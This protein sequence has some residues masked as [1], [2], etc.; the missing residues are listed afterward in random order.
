MLKRVMIS[1]VLFVVLLAGCSGQELSKQQYYEKGVKF[2]ESGNANGAIVVFKKAIEKDQN[3]FEARYQLGRA[4]IL[5]GKF[6][7]A[8]RELLKAL[9]LNPSF[10]D[11]HVALAKVYTM[12]LKTDEALKEINLYLNKT[13]DNPEAY[14]VAASVYAVKKDYAK[15][16]E[17][18]LQA[19]KISPQRASSKIFLADLYLMKGDVRESERLIQETLAADGNNKSALYELAKIRQKQGRQEEVLNV[20][21][22]IYDVDTKDISA[23]L[24]LGMA[25]LQNKNLKKARALAEDVGKTHKDRPESSYLMGTVY[26]YEGKTDD[27]LASLQAAA[28]KTSF[29]GLHYYIGLCHLAKGD[30]EQAISEFR[31]V[32]DMKPGMVQ[33]RLLIASIYLKK[34]KAEDAEME[35]KKVLDIDGK[36]ALAHNLLGSVYIALGRGD[37]AMGEFDR[38]IELAPGLVDSHLKKGAVSL[39]SGDAQKAEEEFVNAVEIAPELLNSRIIL[40]RYYFK[41]RKFDQAIRT[42]K[43]GLKQSADDAVLYNIIGAAYLEAG[44]KGNA[45][46][47]FR[48]AISSNPKLFQPYFSLAR[49]SLD[50]GDKEGAVK[51]YKK[52]LDADKGN[53][54]ALLMLANVME[55]DHKDEEALSYYMKAK[56][57]RKPQAYIALASYYQRKNRGEQAVKVLKEALDLDPKNIQVM[58]L[59]GLIHQAGKNYKDA[60][61]AFRN[62]KVLSPEAG[63]RRTAGVHALM[64]DYDRAI[65]ELR[66]VLAREVNKGVVLG[67]IVA[68]QLQKKSY[69]EAEKTAKEIVA[70][71]PDSDSGHLVLASV[72]SENRRSQEAVNSLKKA[73]QLNPKSIETR[74]AIGRV[75]MSDRNFPKAM[76]VFKELEKSNPQY[77]PAYFL[78][79]NVLELT[80][81]RKGAVEKYKKALELSPDYA[82]A[83]NN[84]AYLY[85]EGL[86]PADRAVDMAKKA[87]ALMPGDGNITD[88]LGWTLYKTGRYDEALK[89]FEEAVQYLPE[90]PSVR[91]HSGLAYLKKGMADKAE[92]QLKESLRLGR[93]K[94]FPESEEAAKTLE[95]VRRK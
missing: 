19:L 81:D 27:A 11:A 1:F 94:P 91:Y 6:D 2:L 39:L 80:G 68:L 20:Y 89:S 25:Y 4:Y 70:L 52:I 36:N 64:G 37:Q 22:K 71:D 95:R 55:V 67:D 75:Y 30:T 26:F 63:A 43:D 14:E 8:E 48:K 53:V 32:L 33:P 17:Y 5:Q 85:A 77:A 74:V 56:E 34:G 47:N 18:L 44:D 69:A 13:S 87:K 62:L 21:Q 50:K 73:L 23:A 45:G 78:Q 65:M 7:S 28:K 83:L 31:K 93:K 72:Y 86:G 88:T 40:A 9:R 90:E 24:Q 61:A 38:A 58:E 12:T 54:A 92:E 60:L 79:A 49:L 84:L 16:E 42:L 35:I 15:A 10:N 3:Y 66:E 76:D 57:Q 59:M 51:E 29:P 82:P 41:S 46:T